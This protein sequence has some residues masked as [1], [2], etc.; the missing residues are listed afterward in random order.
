MKSVKVIAELFFLMFIFIYVLVSA[1]S[2]L[3]HVGSSSLTRDRTQVPCIG[4]AKS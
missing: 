1:R 2:C 3:R 4:S